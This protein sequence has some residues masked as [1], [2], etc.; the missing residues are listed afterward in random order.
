M[1]LRTNLRILSGSACSKLS[2]I[3]P[4]RYNLYFAAI[5]ERIDEI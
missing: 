5:S 2:P 1:P 4:G 3:T